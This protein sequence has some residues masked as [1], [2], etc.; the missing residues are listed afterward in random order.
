[1]M[2]KLTLTLLLTSCM[3]CIGFAQ[4]DSCV[5]AIDI[6][7][8]FGG[9]LDVMQTSEVYDNTSATIG[10]DD[11][12]AG[13]ECFAETGGASLENTMWFSFVGDGNTYYLN[14]GDCGGN[15]SPY[16]N[17]TQIAIYEG[18][19]DGLTVVACNEDEPGTNV[20]TGPW[21]AGVS[22][23]T[24]E[25]VNYLVFLDGWNGTVGQFCFNA[26]QVALSC[27]DIMPGELGASAT[28]ICFR[29]TLFAGVLGADAPVVPITDGVDGFFWMLST[30]AP[31]GDANPA[32][33]PGYLGQFPTQD[34]PYT[35]VFIN[36]GDQVAPN[37]YFLTGITVGNATQLTEV[38]YDYTMACLSYAETIPFTFVAEG[39]ECE[40]EVVSSIDDAVEFDISVGPNPTRDYLNVNWVNSDLSFDNYSIVNLVGQ[41]VLNGELNSGQQNLK[42]D[43]SDLAV[44]QYFLLMQTESGELMQSKIAVSR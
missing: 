2:K 8:I 3:F 42:L 12:T 18:G 35:L 34:G 29:D 30:E 36:N 1:M 23:P 24:T 28:N 16:N 21:Q 20:S 41:Q 27:D 33:N 38:S 13:F 11:P 19:C 25:G 31:I 15:A 6:S 7:A 39:A 10:A 40:E 26:T 17:D 43:L 44:G 14:T 22:F 5:E 9:D 32:A 37:D 4:G